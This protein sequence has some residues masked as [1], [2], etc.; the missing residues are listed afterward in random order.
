MKKSKLVNLVLISAALSSCNKYVVSWQDGVPPYD[1]G[2][3]V[4]K[5]DSLWWLRE[6]ALEQ[7]Y[8][9][10]RVERFDTNHYY[11]N[12]YNFHFNGIVH[13]LWCRAFTTKANSAE[14]GFYGPRNINGNHPVIARGGFG[15]SAH[16]FGAH[17]AAA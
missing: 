3:T 8:G 16:S 11:V 2:K 15:L 17:S 12:H 10:T 5:Q 7:S 13:K 9:N 14:P 1:N 6:M 4:E